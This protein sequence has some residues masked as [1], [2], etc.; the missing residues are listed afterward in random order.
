MIKVLGDSMQTV[1][2]DSP[3]ILPV[4]DARVIAHR[5]DGVVLVAAANSTRR[6]QIREAQKLLESSGANVLG[7]VLNKADQNSS[8]GGYDAYSITSTD[9]S[10]SQSDE[11]DKAPVTAQLELI[12]SDPTDQKTEEASEAD[13]IPPAR[14]HPSRRTNRWAR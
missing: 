14:D 3:P 4:A 5:V 11:P 6:S 7:V 8:Y 1:I 12:E 13:V 10:A 2:I 9:D